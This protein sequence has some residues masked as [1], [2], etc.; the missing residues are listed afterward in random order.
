MVEGTLFSSSCLF[1]GKYCHQGSSCCYCSLCLVCFTLGSS[2]VGNQTR[3]DGVCA[4][5]AFLAVWTE[6]SGLVV[7]K[8]PETAGMFVEPKNNVKKLPGFVSWAQLT[9]DFVSHRSSLELFCPPEN[10][11]GLGVS[12]SASQA[13]RQWR[14]CLCHGCPAADSSGSKPGPLFSR[15]LK[16][17][18]SSQIS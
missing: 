6:S 8:L 11:S 17:N 5:A 4:L 9:Q 12:G 13:L 2:P 15:S 16:V 14:L 10:T 1:M 18:F 3:P 7:W